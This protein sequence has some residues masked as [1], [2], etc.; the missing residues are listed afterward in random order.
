MAHKA[1]KAHTF[2]APK[3]RT[4]TLSALSALSAHMFY[5][6]NPTSYRKPGAE[7]GKK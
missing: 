4:R 5:K 6:R 2:P 7:W 3:S 1:L